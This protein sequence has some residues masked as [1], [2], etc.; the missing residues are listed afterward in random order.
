MARRRAGGGNARREHGPAVNLEQVSVIANAVLYEGYMLYPYRPTSVK[1]QQR[2]TFGGVCPRSYSE[3]QAGSEAWSV[4]TECL[5]LGNADTT[6]EVRARFLHL[7]LRQV[8][9]LPDSGEPLFQP[10]ESLSVAGR[11][12]RGWE[13]AVEREMAVEDLP[14][15]ECLDTTC[16]WPFGFPGSHTIEALHEADGRIAGLIVR[17][18]QP[19]DGAVE[20][21]TTNAGPGLFKLTVRVMNLTGIPNVG[22]RTRSE[23]MQHS[24]ISTHVVLGVSGGTFV[25]MIDP[26]QELRESAAACTN[27]GLWPVVVGTEGEADTM[28]ASPIILYDYPKIAPES[29]GDLFDATEIDEI[30]T[31]RIMTLSDDEKAE[32]RTMDE[33]TRAIL[34]RTESLP[35]EALANMH[36]AMRSPRSGSP[37]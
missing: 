7:L 11:V 16:Q 26:P 5:V 4:Q 31:L 18:Q 19:I 12:V 23:A 3:A 32:L 13:E 17:E 25:S 28:L 29:P 6:L 21:E 30:L 14:I 36:G 10:V 37:T 22:F 15:G 2:W 34:E 8:Q 9:A 20:I 1:N 27:T 24:L 33:R 35:Q